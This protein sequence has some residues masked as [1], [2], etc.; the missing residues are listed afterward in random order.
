MALDLEE[1][2]GNILHAYGAACRNARYQFL[3][4]EDG[5]AAEATVAIG[6]LLDEVGFGSDRDPGESGVHL[7][8]AFTWS[9][10][11]ALGVSDD[12]LATFPEDFREG[13]SARSREHVGD[14]GVNAPDA[15]EDGFGAAH[16]LLM[17][18]SGRED[19]CERFADACVKRAAGALTPVG[20]AQAAG[21]LGEAS[22]DETCGA[23]VHR[24]HFGFADGCSQPSI[25]GVNDNRE[26]DGVYARV[27]RRGMFPNLLEDVGLLRPKREWRLIPPGEFILGCEDE[28]GHVPDGPAPPLGPN[29]TFM[30]YRKL[31]QHVRTFNEHVADVAAQWRVDADALRAK[32]VGRTTAGEPLER[33]DADTATNAVAANA[34]TYEDDRWGERCPMG[35]HI[36]RTHPRDALPGGAEVTTRHRMIRRGMPYGRAWTEESDGDERGLIFVAYVASIAQGFE[37]VQRAWC[38]EGHAFGLGD[39]PDYLLQQSD[40]RPNGSMVIP[41][42]GVLGPP[43]GPLVTVRGSEYLFV[44]SQAGCAW[45]AGLHRAS[46]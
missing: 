33:P 27:P 16:V 5:K 17:V 45:I 35:A 4:V 15:W 46:A 7:N 20:A 11:K 26:S 40:D 2:Q 19:R 14:R 12:V 42:M 37:F 6:E 23:E 36:R 44:P 22:G 10:L 8:L 41:G 21:L 18:H 13:A 9:G 28:D 25:D 34:F 30:V 3:R 1:V 39:S 24:E 38:Y 32:I 43:P 31:E 29:G